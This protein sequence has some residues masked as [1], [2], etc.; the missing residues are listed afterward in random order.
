[1]ERTKTMVTPYNRIHQFHDFWGEELFK[2]ATAYV[3]QSTSVDYLNRGFL[4][5]YHKF[6]KPGAWGLDILAQ[7]HDSILVQFNEDAIDE[8]IPEIAATI[9]SK[10]VI[11]DIEF[12]IPV[13]AKY[14]T[15]WADEDCKDYKLAA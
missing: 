13:E 4:R 6:V 5:V 14:G 11:N 8:A 9:E 3:P 2:S 1:M 10:L 7:S 12:T 15:S